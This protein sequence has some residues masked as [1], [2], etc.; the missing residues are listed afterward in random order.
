[1][2]PSL[3]LPFAATLLLGLALTGGAIVGCGGGPRNT[4]SAVSLGRVDAAEITDA[5][6]YDSRRANQARRPVHSSNPDLLLGIEQWLAAMEPRWQPAKGD[7]RSVRFQIRLTADGRPHSTIWLDN[8]YVQMSDGGNRLR[9]ARL[10]TQETATAA[11]LF[12][13]HP[14]E[15]TMPELPDN[16][17]PKPPE[18][19]VQTMVG[20]R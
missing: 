20:R 16:R 6:A 3:R 4:A 18:A 7:P 10:S 12:G 1:M 15:L 14:S 19:G 11:A 8:G 2:S 17:G 9:G 13:L 5:F